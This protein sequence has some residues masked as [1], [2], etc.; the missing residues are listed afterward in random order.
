MVYNR[1]QPR[2]EEEKDKL[3]ETCFPGRYRSD[4]PCPKCGGTRRYERSGLCVACSQEH[5]RTKYGTGLY[6]IAEEKTTD[7]R[8]KLVRRRRMAESGFAPKGGASGKTLRQRR[9]AIE[10]ELELARIEREYRGYDE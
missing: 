1:K 7:G 2:T 8:T 6:D 4:K 3:S 5:N 10:A 9:Y